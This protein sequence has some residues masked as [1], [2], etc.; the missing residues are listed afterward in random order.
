MTSREDLKDSEEKIEQFL[1]HLAVKSGVAPST[2][3]QAMNALVFLYKKVLKVSLKEEIN[4]IRAQ[5]KMNIP[6][7]KPMESNLIY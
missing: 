6:V 3:N 5:K 4:A 1:I 7:V 2:Q